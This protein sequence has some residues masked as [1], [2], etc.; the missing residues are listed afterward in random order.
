MSEDIEVIEPEVGHHFLE[1]PIAAYCASHSR[2]LQLSHH[3]PAGQGNLLHFRVVL[4]RRTGSGITSLTACDATL[5][6]RFV[7]LAKQYVLVPSEN[8]VARNELVERGVVDPLGVK[9]LLYPF[10]EPN[11]SDL[12]DIAWTCAE[13]QAVQGVYD[14]LIRGELTVVERSLRVGR[15]SDR[16]SSKYECEFF[17]GKSHAGYG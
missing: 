15:Q 7:V 5:T 13:C 11:A 8:A 10:V 2:G 6:L 9:L 4:A 16:R 12:L 17:A 3:P 1:L 14:L